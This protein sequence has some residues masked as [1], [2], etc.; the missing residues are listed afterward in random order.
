[1]GNNS[2]NGQVISINNSPTIAFEEGLDPWNGDLCMFI[3]DPSS[4]IFNFD[5]VGF[6][7]TSVTISPSNVLVVP[8]DNKNLSMNLDFNNNLVTGGTVFINPLQTGQSTITITAFNSDWEKISFYL[9]LTVKS[10]RNNQV[11]RQRNINPLNLL[12][13]NTFSANNIIRTI[14]GVVIP[15]GSDIEFF[16]G[17][18]VTLNAGFEVELG[19]EF[20]ADI[21]PCSNFGTL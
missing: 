16:A 20:L 19:A 4:G 11:I 1:M 10:C 17:N 18:T 8:V 13:E 15:T 9:E 14:G 12:T 2:L 6:D 3:G 5:I 21:R 7:A